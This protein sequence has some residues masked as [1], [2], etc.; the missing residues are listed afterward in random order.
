[1]F[2][3]FLYGKGTGERDGGGKRGGDD[4]M[5]KGLA[6]Q[7]KKDRARQRSA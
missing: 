5:A 4:V 6:R 7:M 1:M 3:E 2:N